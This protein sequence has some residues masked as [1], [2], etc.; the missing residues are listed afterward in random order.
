MM[1]IL[2]TKII[3]AMTYLPHSRNPRTRKKG[4]QAV[5]DDSHVTKRKFLANGLE[6]GHGGSVT[7]AGGISIDLQ[8]GTKIEPTDDKLD[9]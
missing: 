7:V 6:F 4:P 3:I 5:A 8:L 2:M 1:S 9:L